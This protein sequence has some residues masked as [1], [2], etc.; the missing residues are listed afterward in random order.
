MSNSDNLNNTNNV[1]QL[2]KAVPLAN[3]R[4]K[5]E[6]G[7]TVK[8]QAFA[9]A[10]ATGMTLAAAYREVFN[11]PNMSRK[12]M[13]DAASKLMKRPEVIR[14]VNRT[15]EEKAEERRLDSGRTLLFIKDRLLIEAQSSANKPA[16]RLKALELLGKLSDVGAFKERIVTEDISHQ[17]AN[18]IE[19]SIKRKLQELLAS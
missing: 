14:W 17:S 19:E 1:I 2:D 7:L 3:G 13:W 5:N 9:E 12:T 10:V 4:G 15:V 8:Q 18:E 16:D 6:H 11:P